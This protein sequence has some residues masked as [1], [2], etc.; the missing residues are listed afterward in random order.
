MS[1]LFH[2]HYVRFLL[3]DLD[4]LNDWLEHMTRVY[5]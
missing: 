1:T 5:L 2:W 4:V 3:I